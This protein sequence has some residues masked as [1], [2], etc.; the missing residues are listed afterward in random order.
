[1]K[2]CET[3][4]HGDETNREYNCL[5]KCFKDPWHPLWE[6][7]TNGDL[8]R[9]MSDKELSELWGRIYFP[10]K[11]HANCTECGRPNCDFMTQCCP[12]TFLAWLD[13]PA[14]KLEFR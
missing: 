9:E 7:A 11:Y 8:V 4:R 1:M 6:P 2:N 3:C 12:A 13:A 14:D 5:D 10:D